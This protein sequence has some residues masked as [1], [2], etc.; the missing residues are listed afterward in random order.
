MI[1]GHVASGFERV[2]DAFRDNFHLRG[3]LG[4]AV[5]VY[6]GDECLV[7]LWGGVADAATGA[8]WQRDTVLLVFSTT[9]GVAGMTMA[10]AHARGLFE[11]DV[12]V[13]HY[14]P[15]FAQHGKGAITV[16]QLLCHQGGLAAVDAP[17]TPEVLA[18][19]DR[20]DRALA[21]QRP[22]WE[23]GAHHGYHA[24]SLGFYEAALLRRCD[25]RGRGV[26]AYFADEIAGPLGLDF[27]IGLPPSFARERMARIVDFHPL[28]LVRHLDTMP[29]GFVLSYLKPWSITLRAFSNP[30]LERPG[31]LDSPTFWELEFPASTGVGAVRAIARL[32]GELATGATKL[33]VGRPTLDAIEALAPTPRNGTFD[34]VMRVDA[35]YSHGFAKPTHRARFG[36]STRAYGTTG[37]GGSFGYADPDLGIG[38]AYAPNRMGFHVQ[39]DPRDGALRAALYR[40][41]R[42]G[43]G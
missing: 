17:L 27:W 43:A 15:E 11:Y 8:R 18:D 21:A 39:D 13:A 14:W 42:R 2:A 6:R 20:R 19:H 30:R 36:T 32:Y 38:Y 34:Q 22:A 29:R 3:E 35:R 25:P 12:P 24:M 23:P 16:R 28:A 4:A 41:L 26:G 1:D 31:S 7:D 5:A 40:C 37:A 10:L 9:K 33:G